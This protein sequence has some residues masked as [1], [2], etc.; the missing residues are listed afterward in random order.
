MKF[1]RHHWYYVGIYLFIGLAFI[2][3]FWGNRIEEIQKILI[4]SFMALLVHQFEE[5]ACPGGFPPIFNIAVLGEKKT[6][7][8]YPLNANQCLVTNVYMAYFFYILAI[9]FP[10][11]IWLGLAQVLF[12]MLQVLVHGVVVNIRLKS[13]YNPG[14]GSALL[15]HVPIG[16]YYV[17]YVTTNHLIS[18][19]DWLF[20]I[21]VTLLATFATVVLPIRLMGD[22]KSKYPFNQREMGGYAKEKV[23]RIREAK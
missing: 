8:R 16:I 20:G 5:Y 13:I 19:K 21:I 10:N 9:L 2:M 1:Y 12:G 6:P 18:G 7:E 22:K 3:G 4:Y 11:L 15:L 17:F 23:K 14:L